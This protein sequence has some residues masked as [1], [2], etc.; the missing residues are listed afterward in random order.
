M[1]E[2]NLSEHFTLEEF[3]KPTLYD[4]LMYKNE[5]TGRQVVNLWA[6]CR[7]V[8]EPLREL[9]GGPIIITSGFRSPAS[10]KLVGGVTFSQHLEGRA[11]DFTT[12]YDEHWQKLVRLIEE[13]ELPVSFDQCI[14]YRRRRFIHISFVTKEKNRNWY[15]IRL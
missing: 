9:I 11:A 5:P 4:G 12:M 1:I 3:T 6:L 8:L 15:I 2:N 13:G 14:L 10:N 7:N